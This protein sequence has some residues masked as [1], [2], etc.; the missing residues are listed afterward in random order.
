MG[1]MV[2]NHSATESA[3][4]GL[5]RMVAQLAQAPEMQRMADQLLG[6]S[7]DGGVAQRSGR[8]NS[9]A[10]NIS[11]LMQTMLPMMTQVRPAKIEHLLC[12]LAS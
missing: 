12:M 1:G 7:D 6:S 4:P 11:G 3:T 9:T 8:R 10:P 2:S 5:M